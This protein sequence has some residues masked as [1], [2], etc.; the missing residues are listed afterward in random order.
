MT[1]SLLRFAP[2]DSGVLITP[3]RRRQSRFEPPRG[4]D[5][6]MRKST[7]EKTNGEMPCV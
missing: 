6:P 4:V 3:A 2:S 1:D 7:N 5:V